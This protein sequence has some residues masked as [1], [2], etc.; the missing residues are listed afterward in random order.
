MKYRDLIGNIRCA[1]QEHS[2]RALNMW[3]VSM[4]IVWFEFLYRLPGKSLLSILIGF[5]K[6]EVKNSKWM[7]HK[8][9]PVWTCWAQNLLGRL[10]LLPSSKIH[11]EDQWPLRMPRELPDVRR[12]R[13]VVT[14]ED[15]NGNTIAP[16]Q[17]QFNFRIADKT[18]PNKFTYP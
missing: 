2:I 11:L 12:I 6:T 13:I 10:H 5:W 18:Y 4:I 9:L 16:M 3:N 1:C 17:R 7:L 8:M 15:R 14:L